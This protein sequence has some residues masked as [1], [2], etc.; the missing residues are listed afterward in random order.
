MIIVEQGQQSGGGWSRYRLWPEL[1]ALEVTLLVTKTRVQSTQPV[2][3]YEHSAPVPSLTSALIRLR[4]IDPNNWIML[5]QHQ[6]LWSICSTSSASKIGRPKLMGLWSSSHEWEWMNYC[7]L[8][9]KHQFAPAVYGKRMCVQ[10]VGWRNLGNFKS[11]GLENRL[12]FHDWW[13]TAGGIKLGWN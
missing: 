2:S 3:R 8:Y 1:L 6:L 9:P 13:L 10:F 11:Y 4:V 7:N 12:G 5:I